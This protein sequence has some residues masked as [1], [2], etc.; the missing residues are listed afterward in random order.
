MSAATETVN[1]TVEAG[2]TRPGATVVDG[3]VV[4]S[5]AE[6]GPTIVDAVPAT[7][8]AGERKE[9]LAPLAITEGSSGRSGRGD[10]TD[11]RRSIGDRA[12]ARPVDD[13]VFRFYTAH[14]DSGDNPYSEEDVLAQQQVRRQMRERAVR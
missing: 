10:A 13:A 14:A 8:G 1:P 2:V 6:E 4:H 9:E 7:E 3:V 12:P 11:R 5:G